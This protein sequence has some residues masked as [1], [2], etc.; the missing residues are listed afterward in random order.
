MCVE[1]LLQRKS[2][3]YYVFCVCVCVCVL[4]APVIQHAMSM[5]RTVVCGLSGCTV[6]STLSH[7]QHDLGGG[8]E[9]TEHKMWVSI[10]SMN[11][12]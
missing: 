1:P 5:R 12:V 7:K 11:F 2:S 10:F 9:V 8:E 4:V 3:N 6:F